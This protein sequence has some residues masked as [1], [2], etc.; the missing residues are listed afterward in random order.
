MDM[1][2]FPKL[3]KGLYSVAIPLSTMQFHNPENT[4]VYWPPGAKPLPP[5]ADIV[6][7]WLMREPVC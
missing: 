7:G 5:I 6:M 1:A 3:I 4:V 2:I